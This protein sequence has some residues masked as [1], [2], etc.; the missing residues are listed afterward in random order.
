MIIRCKCG[1]PDCLNSLILYHDGAVYTDLITH[2]DFVVTDRDTRLELVRE[3]LK[4]EGGEDDRQAG[5]L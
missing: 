4:I 5:S 3:L 2:R 1:D